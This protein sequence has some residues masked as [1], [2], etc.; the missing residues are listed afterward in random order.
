MFFIVNFSLPENAI[1][2]VSRMLLRQL[3]LKIWI[4]PKFETAW[5]WA[6]HDVRF[7]P[8][9]LSYLKKNVEPSAKGP[10]RFLLESL[11][12]QPSFS[13]FWSGR[14]NQRNVAFVRRQDS[15][16][17]VD[18]IQSSCPKNIQQRKN[19]SKFDKHVN[20]FRAQSLPKRITCATSLCPAETRVKILI[21]QWKLNQYHQKIK[22]ESFWS[23][24]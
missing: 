9:E 4:L 22:H 17:Y 8:R 3:T 21:A 15:A 12:Y 13:R 10:A 19:K 16:F 18:M 1:A 14:H 23:L 2:R 7:W 20:I 24:M 11:C 6:Y 5:H